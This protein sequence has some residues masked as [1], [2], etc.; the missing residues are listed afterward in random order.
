MSDTLKVL[1]IEDDPDV[2]LGCEQALQLEGIATESVGSAEEGERRLQK[3]F[4]GIIV[5][6]IRLPHMDGMAFLRQVQ[7]IDAELPV[8]LITGHGDVSMAVQAMK[9]GA[10]DF[11]QKPFSPD[12]L[13]EVVRRALEKRR[14]VIEVRDLRYRLEGRDQIEAR[15]IGNAASMGR[16]RKMIAGLADSAADVLI[17]GET[18]TGKEL[19][20][21]CLHEASTRR[22]ATLRSSRTLPGQ[23]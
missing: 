7:A 13:V 4:R 5:S 19:V 1:V 10:Y 17:Q 20:A 2:R 9:D 8:V 3:D 16:V 6:D 11:I 18:G 14:L 12:Y 21:R 15:L 23:R 22:S